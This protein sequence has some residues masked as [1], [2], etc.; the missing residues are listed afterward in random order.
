M[1]DFAVIFDMDGVI[2]DTNPHHKIAIQQFCASHGIQLNELTFQHK[3]YG[4]T[5]RD[6]IINVFG[7][8]T[9]EQR[10]TYAYEKEA[11][12]RKMYTPVPVT[13]L[14]DFLDM[15][16]AN[17]IPRAIATSAP[18]ENVE[19]IVNK[20]GIRKYFDIILDERNV[21][22]GKPNP[23]IYLKT[24]KALGL[25]NSQCIVIEDS[26]SGIT[27]ARKAGSKVIG[28]TTTHTPAEMAETNLVINDFRDLT[29][30]VLT[31]L[32]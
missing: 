18:P 26:L 5:N 32:I 14:I 16:V 2:V 10:D 9:D 25:P 29:L 24:A 19:F 31:G 22:N 20:I 15:L 21:T 3:I 13:G 27:A 17:K 8:I 6:W 1:S 28:I 12:F 23:E 7:E 11:L 4:R 30:P